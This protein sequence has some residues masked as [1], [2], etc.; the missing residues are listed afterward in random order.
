MRFLHENPSLKP[1]KRCTDTIL[2]AREF[3]DIDIIERREKEEENTRR[4]HKGLRLARD[5]V[6]APRALV[7]YV[8][9]LP[10]E[11]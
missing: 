1:R 11:F 4:R 7:F 5:D 3:G 8:R 2:D 9:E 6:A 10:M